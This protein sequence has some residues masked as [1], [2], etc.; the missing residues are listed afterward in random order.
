MR[1]KTLYIFWWYLSIDMVISFNYCYNSEV[2]IVF[3]LG[4]ILL[5]AGRSCWYESSWLCSQADSQRTCRPRSN[6]SRET[7]DLIITALL[8]HIPASD[9]LFRPPH[10]SRGRQDLSPTQTHDEEGGGSGEVSLSRSLT[11]HE[12]YAIIEQKKL[13]FLNFPI[14]NPSFT[15]FP[16]LKP[17]CQHNMT[18]RLGKIG[19]QFCFNTVIQG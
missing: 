11:Q 7:G 18:L 17:A 2:F 9:W 10:L 15:K 13:I 5:V 19:D 6:L 16:G 3:S 1:I 12:P 14:N 4:L 8:S